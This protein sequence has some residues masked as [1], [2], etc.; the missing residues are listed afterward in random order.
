MYAGINAFCHEPLEIRHLADTSKTRAR[1]E[2]RHKSY[3]NTLVGGAG[4]EPSEISS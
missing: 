1:P 3:G 2:W 4:E